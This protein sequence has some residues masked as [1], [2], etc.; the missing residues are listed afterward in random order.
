MK[1][2]DTVDNVIKD[3]EPLLDKWFVDEEHSHIPFRLIGILLASDDYYYMLESKDLEYIMLPVAVS[4]EQ[5][6]YARVKE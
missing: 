5:Y 1:L 2:Y 4:L 3:V 6:G